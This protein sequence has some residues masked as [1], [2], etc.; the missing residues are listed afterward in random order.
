VTDSRI[1][2]DADAL[3]AHLDALRAQGRRIV[4]TNGCFEILHVGHV[5]YLEAARREGDVLVV[6]VNSD[7]SM[8]RIKP[9][10]EIVVPDEERM[11]MLAALRC[12]DAVLLFDEDTPQELLAR[13]RPDVH[14]KGTDYRADELPERRVVESHGG[15]I[16]ILGD[17]KTRSAT[18]LRKRLSGER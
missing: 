5:S 2:R 10:R 17:P 7:A 1:W 16:A 12:V 3:V 6:L 15:R 18:E 14:A 8:G 11:A 4:T 9:D 13:I